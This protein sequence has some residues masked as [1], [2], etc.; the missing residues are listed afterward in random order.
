MKTGG[1]VE[2]P[3]VSKTF[4]YCTFFTLK[5]TQTLPCNHMFHKTCSDHWTAQ[6]IKKLEEIW[7][8]LKRGCVR[9]LPSP[10]FY[11]LLFL[12]EISFRLGVRELAM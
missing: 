3:K 8:E 10:Y 9:S 4:G 5:D 2:F 7:L 1:K 12:I 6:G 11:L